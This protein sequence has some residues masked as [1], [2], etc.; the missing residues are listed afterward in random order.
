[1]FSMFGRLAGGN[2]RDAKRCV[3][4]ACGFV[5]EGLET[6]QLLSGTV[7]SLA[8]PAA[9]YEPPMA[10]VLL[11]GAPAPNFTL[12]YHNLLGDYTLDADPSQVKVLTFFATWSGLSLQTAP[13]INEVYDWTLLNT[14]PVSVTLINQ[15]ET[16]AVVDQFILDQGLGF[17]VPILM[18]SGNLV[19]QGLYDAL[20]LPVTY[21]IADGEIRY[22]HTGYDS[23]LVT[24]LENEIDS[25]L[26]TPVVS[27]TDVTVFESAATA[28]FTVALS[29]P[30]DVDITVTY[31]V[32]GGTATLTGDFKASL[33]N[34]VPMILNVTFAA[35]ETEQIIQIPI[36]NDMLVEPAEQ[37]F[38][39]LTNVT[40]AIIADGTGVGTI[41]DDDTPPDSVLM[42][43]TDASVVEGD[44]GVT[45]MVF[46]VTMSALLPFDLTVDYTTSDGST[47][48]PATAGDDYEA[49]FGTLTFAAGETVKTIEVP[50]FG[51]TVDEPY[52]TLDLTL[53]NV[54]RVLD[55]ELP[56]PNPA[57]PPL[58]VPTLVKD[59]GIGTIQDDEPFLSIGDIVVSEGDAGTTLID[60]VITL[61]SP[62]TEPVTVEYAT[63]NGT[64]SV[65]LD[66]I[67]QRNSVTFDVDDLEQTI[68]IEIV[69]DL[70]AEP[71]EYFFIQLVSSTGAAIE[72]DQS[73]GMITILNET[74]VAPPTPTVSISDAYGVIEGAAGA[75][76]NFTIVL[77][78]ASLENVRV[79]YT[80]TGGTATPDID[81][82]SLPSQVVIIPAGQTS[83]IVSVPVTNDLLPEAN[84]TVIVT[85]TD[86]LLAIPGDM[87]ATGIIVEDEA[88]PTITIADMFMTEGN[89]YNNMMV[90]T[91][92]LSEPSGQV[93]TV[94]YT[95][96]SGTAN[97]ADH[98]PGVGTLVFEPGEL[99]RTVRVMVYADR[100]A[101]D[102][103]YFF[104]SLSGEAGATIARGTG[105]GTIV[106]DDRF[107]KAVVRN[108]RGFSIADNRRTPPVSFGKYVVGDYGAILTFTVTNQGS[109]E[110]RLGKVVVPKG[111]KLIEGLRNPLAPSESDTFKVQVLT[112]TPGARAGHIRFATNDPKAKP[113]N[114]AVSAKI[115]DTDAARSARKERVAS[116]LARATSAEVMTA[117]AKSRLANL[118]A[119]EAKGISADWLTDEQA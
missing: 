8:T 12:P 86:P 45:M 94:N 34:P 16:P 78:T 42:N 57:D 24:K 54:L 83:Y 97:A 26:N 96:L 79:R 33:T 85:L 101:E 60:F 77:S 31:S 105:V 76:L 99:S 40:N 37:F 117:P 30:S 111:F 80:I 104:V 53:S 67:G 13:Q 61:S 69:G 110:L 108:E 9:P 38:V 109:G 23:Q 62:A 48:D 18:D 36:I 107:A 75:A 4:A 114:F 72:A 41:I 84:E 58:P 47:G 103:E 3:A 28:D 22:V 68:Q 116:S 74:D 44:E 32:T 73:Q 59:I 102:N 35:G 1:M 39:T 93:V 25:I 70:L 5:L 2:G 51:D 55:P 15:D 92:S 50:I 19:G 87:V 52:E 81:Y 56:P 113:Y 29:S 119:V 115:N 89:V 98:E 10:A 95:T 65:V 82:V 112:N 66:F 118:F 91:V 71:D 27:V 20:S 11:A 46:T 106:D 100:S 7:E 49:T 64:A 6:R 43:I 88:P 63:V 21:V 17:M 14:L 90:F